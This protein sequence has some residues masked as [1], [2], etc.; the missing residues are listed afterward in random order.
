M[1]M[2]KWMPLKNGVEVIDESVTALDC[3]QKK[4]TL[5]NLSRTRPG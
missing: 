1:L 5:A 4:I 3:K 2:S